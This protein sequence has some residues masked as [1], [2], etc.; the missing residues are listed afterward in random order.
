MGK[1][2]ESVDNIIRSADKLGALNTAAILAFFC[3]VFLLYILYLHR[4]QRLGS[5][6]AWKA[7]FAE[8]DADRM[9]GGAVEQGFTK[10]TERLD[11]VIERLDRN[12]Y[13]L[14][15]LQ[16]IKLTTGDIHVQVAKD[17]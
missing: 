10:V 3:L 15:E 7:R 1:I 6:L 9:V 2:F 17:S 8:A 13:E 12:E 14:R 16:K 11:K 4:Q 5:E